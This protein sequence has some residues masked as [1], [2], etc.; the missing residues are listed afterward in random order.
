[1][2]KNLNFATTKMIMCGNLNKRFPWLLLFYPWF[3]YANTQFLSNFF[4]FYLLAK[5]LV[6]FLKT[7]ISRNGN[8]NRT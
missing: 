7:L 5:I 1:M 3:L 6:T 8:I 2:T 4:R